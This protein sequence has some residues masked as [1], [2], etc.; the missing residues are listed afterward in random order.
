MGEFELIEHIKHLA[1]S[2]EG[3]LG[4]GDDCAV[5]P[6][7]GDLETLV[8]TDMLMEGVHFLL[9]DIRP[10][11]LGWKSIAVN[12]SDIAAMGGT[13]CGSFLSMALPPS[14]TS[15]KIEAF[16]EGYIHLS[17]RLGCPLLGGDT[18][19]SIG[20]LCIN[21][22]VTGT[23]KKG[24]SLKRSSALPGDGIYVSGTLGDSAAGLK[25]ILD[26]CK[27]SS[28]SPAAQAPDSGQVYPDDYSYLISRHYQPVPRVELGVRL[29]SD[30]SVHAMMDISDGLASDLPHILEASHAGASIDCSLIPMSLQFKRFCEQRGLDPLELSLCGGEDYELLFTAADQF[31]PAGLPVTRIGTI[32]AARVLE[33]EGQNR[34]F[35]GYRHF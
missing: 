13:P 11:Q 6:Q 35:E 16:L 7:N 17:R 18:V 5:L 22:T 28:A 24:I 14:F 12:I 1:V 3:V 8:S 2:P 25:C 31:S 10:Y 27:H 9:D 26:R 23:C 29:A 21:V 34:I 30:P 20:P 19:S 32:T 4:I 15:E 33:W